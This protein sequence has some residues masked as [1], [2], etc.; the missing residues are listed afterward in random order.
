MVADAKRKEARER[1]FGAHNAVINDSGIRSSD[2][3]GVVIDQPGCKTMKP[4]SSSED[5]NLHAKLQ[6]HNHSE[7]TN[8][9]QS[10]EENN[11]GIIKSQKTKRFIVFIG[12][13]LL[14]FKA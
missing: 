13:F 5:T 14:C 9:R 10:I 3:K 11:E 7:D 1:K 8:Y 12:L 4:S 2:I 6:E